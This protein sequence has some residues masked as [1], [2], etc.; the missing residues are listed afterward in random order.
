MSP[1]SASLMAPAF[2]NAYWRKQSRIRYREHPGFS[3]KKGHFEPEEL[4]AFAARWA[5]ELT[6]EE[7]AEEVRQI[8]EG[9]VALLANKRS[10]M[11]RSDCDLVCEQFRF[12]IEAMQDPEDPEYILVI[13]SLWI[14]TELNKLSAQ[15]DELFPHSF[16]EVVVPVESNAERGELLETLEHWEDILDGRISESADQSVYRLHLKS[17]FVMA[18]DLNAREVSFAKAAVEGPLHLAAA[19]SAELK[20]LGIVKQIL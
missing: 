2:E 3:K 8:Y 20:S 13:R 11:E 15:F 12:S 17:G 5:S 10:R 1:M 6:R 19:L 4:N 18:I 16:D 9:C 14:K 7:S